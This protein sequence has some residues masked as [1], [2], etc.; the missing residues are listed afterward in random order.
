MSTARLPAMPWC[1][2]VVA[3]GAGVGGVVGG[4]AALAALGLARWRGP[5]AVAAGAFVMLA[6]ACVLTVLEAP[7]SGRA[8]DYLFNFALDRPWASH[9]GLAAGVLTLVGI[10][11]AARDERAPSSTDGGPARTT[12]SRAASG[13]PTADRE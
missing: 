8:A 9:A 7:A 11:L 6:V 10:V 4:L 3:I 13:D 2:V 1:V 5:R 12:D